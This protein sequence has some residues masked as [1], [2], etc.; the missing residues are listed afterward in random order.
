MRMN[1]VIVSMQGISKSFPGVKALDNVRFELRSGEVMALLG[2]NGAGKSTLMKI[3]SGVY[4]RDAGTIEIFGKSYGDLTPKQAQAVGVAIIHQE[5]N[6]CRHLTVAENMFLGREIYKGFMLDNAAMEREAARV[7]GELKIDI[8]PRQVVGDLPVS[9]QQ[10]VEIAK[11]LSTNA[12]VLIMDEPTSALTSKEIDDLFRIIRQ[13]RANGCG[14]VYISH[15]L[16]ELAHIVDRVTIMRDGQYITSMNFQDVTLDEIIAHMVGREIKEKFPR[17]ECEKGKKVFE[18][19]HLNAGRMVRD[20][21][22]E[23]YEGEIV[24]F[25]GLMGAG[26]TETTRAIFGVDPKES[27]EILLDGK[28]VSIRSPH[29]AIQAGIVLAPEDRKKDGL[30]TKLSIRHNIALPNLDLL[31]NRLGVVSTTKEDAMCDQAVDNLKIKTPNVDVD[32]GNLSGGNQQKVVVGKW[33]A[34]NSRVVMFDE[35]TRGIDVA[36]KVEIYNL[37]NQLKQQGI[38]VMFVSSEMPEVMGIADRI[39]VMCDG[40]ITGELS[41]R[42][43]TQNEILTYATRFENKF[44]QDEGSAKA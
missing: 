30:C 2:E 20:V 37:M 35:P 28:P 10:M 34:R 12:R 5:L 8:S 25:A 9:K 27:G 21:S 39:I 3:L 16:E 26:R 1:E 14:I 7:L 6:M 31:C 18:V 38:A 23:L 32:A 19:K 40:R 29:D 41:A 42:E 15:R 4:T 36:A 13:L 22:F 11:A 17:V 44:A 24:G 43:T 33:L